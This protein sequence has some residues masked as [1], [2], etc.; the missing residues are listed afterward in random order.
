[1]PCRQLPERGGAGFCFENLVA[2]PLQSFGQ[3]PADEGFI[4]DNQNRGVGH[5]AILTEA[6]RCA[7][8]GP[9]AETA[10]LMPARSC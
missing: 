4:V 9:A 2:L 1:M 5:G 6:G 3:R 8:C 10:P 7:G